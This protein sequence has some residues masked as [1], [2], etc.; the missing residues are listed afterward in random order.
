QI[1][2]A[3]DV[4]T[5]VLLNARRQPVVVYH[6]LDVGNRHVQLAAVIITRIQARLELSNRILGSG[7]SPSISADRSYARLGIIQ[8]R[9]YTIQNVVSIR[10]WIVLPIVAPR[11]VLLRVVLLSPQRQCAEDQARP[12][13][14]FG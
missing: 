4:V 9:T 12:H 7:D 14:R 13:Q 5:Q 2:Q 6:P 10:I 3:A 11:L 1:A 8:I